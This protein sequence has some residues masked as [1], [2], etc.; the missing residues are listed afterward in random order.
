M[1]NSR[2]EEIADSM[3]V[4]HNRT[5]IM[6]GLAKASGSA[7]LVDS[8]SLFKAEIRYYEKRYVEKV[9]NIAERVRLRSMG[10]T[11]RWCIKHLMDLN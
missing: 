10:E 9:G 3:G 1:K 8:M 11:I 5:T 4:H 2:I 7:L 6:E